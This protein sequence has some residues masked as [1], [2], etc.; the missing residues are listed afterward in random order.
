[1]VRRHRRSLGLRPRRISLPRD[2]ANDYRIVDKDVA[3]KIRNSVEAQAVPFAGLKQAQPVVEPSPLPVV[4][5]ARDQVIRRIKESY[6]DEKLEHLVAALLEAQGFVVDEAVPG[7][8]QGVDVLAG[9][10]P[11]G[12]DH[13]RI[14]VQVKHTSSRIGQPEVQ[15]LHGAMQQFDADQGLF[16]SWSDYTEDAKKMARLNFFLMRLWNA[17]DLLEAVYR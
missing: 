9:H 8:D 2:E 4:E 1:M 6:P 3:A 5:L 14:C 10:G 11:L 17:N 7:K 16:V 12:F 13:P 15:Q